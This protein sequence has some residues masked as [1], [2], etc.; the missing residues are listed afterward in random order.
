MNGSSGMPT[1]ICYNRYQLNR[2]II[3]MIIDLNEIAGITIPECKTAQNFRACAFKWI[4]KYR[5]PLEGLEYVIKEKLNE[6][7]GEEESGIFS[8]ELKEI[9]EM[10]E[11]KEHK[12]I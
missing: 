9:A 5:D 7:R 12:E 8:E 3:N 1:R 6:K 11:K 2:E 4:S 10:L